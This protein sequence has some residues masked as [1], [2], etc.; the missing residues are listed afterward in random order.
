MTLAQT[1]GLMTTMP[2]TL[3][4]WPIGVPAWQQ[5]ICRLLLRRLSLSDNTEPEGDLRFG[6]DEQ[7]RFKSYLL[8]VPLSERLELEAGLFVLAAAVL[9][10]HEPTMVTAPLPLPVVL[11]ALTGLRVSEVYTQ[12]HE[13]DVLVDMFVRRDVVLPPLF[14]PADVLDQAQA[15]VPACRVDLKT[16][17]QTTPH[18]AFL[19]VPLDDIYLLDPVGRNTETLLA[20]LEQGRTFPDVDP[21]TL[22][23]MHAIL[24]AQPC[25]PEEAQALGDL[26]HSIRLRLHPHFLP[27]HVPH[28]DVLAHAATCWRLG[29]DG[30]GPRHAL[31]PAAKHLQDD[32]LAYARRLDARTQR[33]PLMPAGVIPRRDWPNVRKSARQALSN[34]TVLAHQPTVTVPVSVLGLDEHIPAQRLMMHLVFMQATMTGPVW[35][36]HQD[37]HTLMQ[38]LGEHPLQAVSLTEALAFYQA[39][40]L[41]DHAILAATALAW[42]ED[43]RARGSSAVRPREILAAAATGLAQLRKA[44]GLGLPLSRDRAV[45]EELL[46]A[47]WRELGC[48][49]VAWLFAPA[50]PEGDEQ[51]AWEERLEWLCHP[52]REQIPEKT[53]D[54]PTWDRLSETVL[55]A[56]DDE[57][58]EHEVVAAEPHR[59]VLSR[60]LVAQNDA[61][62][63]VL[64]ALAGKTLV[65]LGGI[66]KPNSKRRL[67]E[68]LGLKDVDWIPSGQYDHG[69][70]ADAHL[71]DPNVAAVVF[72]LRW[73]GHAHGSI[74]NR[75]WALGIPAASLPGG[76]NPR[77][78]L[79]QLTV[80]CS[81][82]LAHSA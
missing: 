22:A 72:A 65:L 43:D 28:Q 70:Q 55:S 66:P 5:T 50:G 80:Q 57:D 44:V 71:S 39:Q 40:P 59:A 54:D 26:Q 3:S 9:H 41:I 29:T 4:A 76:Y 38:R 46:K 10:H 24:S 48:P 15:C 78:I 58:E 16:F 33:F 7:A 82:R 64:R 23:A 2:E 68:A 77:Q 36:W 11:A 60:R 1:N 8:Q 45:L 27:G 53:F 14:D 51:A 34:L 17:F 62:A 30:L 47:L 56:E 18:G 49:V 74:R 63:S 42:L 61:Q 69:L 12:G 81:Q 79:H 6:E 32:L 25:G 37:V 67:I 13:S 75:A 73:A 31:R 21:Q 19:D 52:E 35:Q 20:A